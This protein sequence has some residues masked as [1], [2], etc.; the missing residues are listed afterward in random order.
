VDSL[1]GRIDLDFTGQALEIAGEPLPLWVEQSG[2]LDATGIF[3]ETILDRAHTAI[4]WQ[5]GKEIHLRADHSIGSRNQI[6]IDVEI[7]ETEQDND[8]RR[9][10][11]R[12]RGSPSESIRA[13]ELNLK[14]PASPPRHWPMRAREE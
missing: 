8:K 3:S 4:E 13:Q 7:D 2:K 12:D 14:H 10:Q 9:E 6:V 11:A 1:Y 5:R